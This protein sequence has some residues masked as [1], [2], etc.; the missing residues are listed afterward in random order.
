MN[1]ETIV[2]HTSSEIAIIKGKTMGM[3]WK[4]ELSMEIFLTFTSIYILDYCIIS[5][6]FQWIK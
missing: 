5:R 4:E 6:L 2:D 1:K 3:I